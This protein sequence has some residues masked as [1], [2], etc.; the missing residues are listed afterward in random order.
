MPAK[1]QSSSKKKHKSKSGRRGRKQASDSDSNDG[2]AP[3]KPKKTDKPVCAQAF[4]HTSTNRLFCSKL[5]K[6]ILAQQ[7]MSSKTVASTATTKA[8]S[9]YDLID[10]LS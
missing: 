4:E 1:R 6:L 10:L 2:P 5:S 7:V 8:G 3:S 9:S